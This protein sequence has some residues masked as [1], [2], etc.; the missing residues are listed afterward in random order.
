MEWW[1]GVLVVTAL[2]VLRIAVPAAFVALIGYALHRLEIKW[3]PITTAGGG[4]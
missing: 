4:E 2:T 3:H 1:D